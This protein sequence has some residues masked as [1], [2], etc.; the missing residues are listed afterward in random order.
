MKAVV[1]DAKKYRAIVI[2]NPQTQ[3]VVG[4]CTVCPKY[5]EI[6]KVVDNTCYVSIRQLAED[7]GRTVNYDP[8]T[9]TVTVGLQE[10]K[11]QE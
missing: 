5:K 8:T 3:G 1:W 6:V 11:Q 4:Y 7:F 10:Y 2:M 9:Q